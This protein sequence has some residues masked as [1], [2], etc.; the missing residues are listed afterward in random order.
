MGRS[1]ETIKDGPR[2]THDSNSSKVD[3]DIMSK[4]RKTTKIL[5]NQNSEDGSNAH[6]LI[7]RG[8]TKRIRKEEDTLFSNLF[9]F[10]GKAIPS[11][12]KHINKF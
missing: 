5:Q 8:L 4:M 7:S 11:T 6:N 3:K 12:K 2:T 10:M 9:H 1:L